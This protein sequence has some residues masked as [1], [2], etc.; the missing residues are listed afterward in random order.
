MLVFSTHL[1]E[2]LPLYNLLSGSTLPPSP[3]PCVNK[4]T[5]YT[6]TVCFGGG[7][8]MGYGILGPETDKYLPQSSF[9]SN[10]LDD[11]ILYCLPGVLS[12]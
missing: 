11:D 4:Y 8:G 1:C 7:G 5:V 2:L 9:T 10:F 6:Y 12:F 3:L